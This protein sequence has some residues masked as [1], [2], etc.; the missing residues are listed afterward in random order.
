MSGCERGS[1]PQVPLGDLFNSYST[2]KSGESDPFG[3]LNREEVM[4]SSSVKYL[5]EQLHKH[6]IAFKT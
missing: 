4:F 5:V 6:D 2:P 1:C 3:E